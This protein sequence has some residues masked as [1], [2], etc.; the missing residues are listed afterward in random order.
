V[1]D[2][3]VLVVGAGFSGAVLARE[4]AEKGHHICV[5]DERDHVAGNC[6]T[7]TDEASGVMVHV[8]GPHIF[9]T[10]NAK[11]WNY[12]NK[13]GEMMPYKNQV[14]ANVGGRIFS[15]PINLHT[16]NQ[17]F[18]KSF[19][20]DEAKK[21]ISSQA[22][23][24]ILE[25]ISFE[26]QAMKF[27]GK[28]MYKAFFYGYTK[29]QWGVEPSLLPASILKRL[30]LRFNYNDDYFS[31]HFQGIPR[32]G[33]T[34][35]VENI[36]KHKNIDLRLNTSSEQTKGEFDHIIYSG[37][38]DRYFD[39]CDGRLSYRTLKFEQFQYDG[40]FQGT[41]V[42]NY[43]D[44]DIPFTRISEHKHFAPW[45]AEKF[46]YSPCFYEYSSA[47]GKDDVPFYPVSLVEDKAL[48]GQYINRAEKKSNITF[49]GR[50]GTYS[51][52]DMDVSILRALETAT[53]LDK[54]W[55][56]GQQGMAFVHNPL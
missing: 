45:S 34:P 13:F 23:T 8:Y 51:Y 11:V 36:L 7:K 2:L 14:K 41:A 26:D 9:H 22:D 29:K 44:Q 40:D 10:D 24:T 12:I 31:H 30:P 27:V 46:E 18:G 37:P 54:A 56:N 3:K 33:Y 1:Q 38:I 4:L 19:S 25:P 32:H 16:I 52:L 17:F 28:A 53:E 48:L 5:I 49:V 42:M 21:F 47:C 55:K 20:P 6:H 50:L 43:C 35:I 39:F 15:L